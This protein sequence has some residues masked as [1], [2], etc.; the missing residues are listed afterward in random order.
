MR[1]ISSE[2]HL[3]CEAFSR[4]AGPKPV[5]PTQNQGYKLAL[6]QE[7]QSSGDIHLSSSIQALLPTRPSATCLPPQT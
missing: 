2:A 3:R 1:A 5:L 7:W 6:T 4:Q